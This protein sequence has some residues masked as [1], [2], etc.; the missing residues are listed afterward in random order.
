MKCLFKL[1]AMAVLLV[2]LLMGGVVFLIDKLVETAVTQSVGYTT[3]QDTTLESASLGILSG[4]MSLEEL[5]ISNPPGFQETPL[6]R[7]GRF[8]TEANLSNFSG[9]ELELD[10][11]RLQGLELALEIKGSE[12]N[13]T[14]LLKRLRELQEQLNQDGGGGSEDGPTGKDSPGKPQPDDPG[15]VVKINRIHITGVTASMTISE[16]PLIDGV[17]AFEVP[18][19]TLDDFSSDMDRAT[20]VE[21]TAHILEELLVASLAAADLE[22]P[23]EVSALLDNDLLRS[24]LGEGLL[25]GDFDQ[26]E[27]AARKGLKDLLEDAK[28]DPGGSLEKAKNDLDKLFGNG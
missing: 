5:K 13:I 20:M 17:Y 12:T 23:G 24:G 15:P 14:Q 18:E 11:V 4:N 10:L 8:E 19:M 3:Q 27:D 28:N 9:D 21:W 1:L 25:E 16:V 7:M 2:L 6:L 22:L 26:L